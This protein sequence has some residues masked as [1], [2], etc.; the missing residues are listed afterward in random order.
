MESRLE[1]KPSSASSPLPEAADDGAVLPTDVWDVSRPATIQTSRPSAVTAM[2]RVI[3]SKPFAQLIAGLVI[4]AAWQ[5]VTAAG[6]VRPSLSATPRQVADFLLQALQTEQLWQ[7]LGSTLLATV[8]AF[9][10]GSAVGIVVGII[11][12]LLPRLE[13]A[14][15]P[16]LSALNSMPRI[17]L[18]PLFVLY[19]GFGTTSKVALAFSL[20]VFILITNAR[21]G[22]VGVDR[23]LLRLSAAYGASKVQTVLKI[24][25]PSSVPSIFAGLRVG[26]VYSLLGVVTSELIAA[27]QGIGARITYYATSFNMQGIYGLLILLALIGVTLNGIM[28]LVERRL[29]RWQTASGSEG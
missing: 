27:Q 28:I 9:V 20:V 5:A 11:L 19:F 8:I 2:R 29:L 10:L 16:Y 22:V 4:L 26:L 23:E 1:R 18:A 15:D 25:L 7:D 3:S 14:V 6:L 12:G 24:L 17:A 13:A 21:A